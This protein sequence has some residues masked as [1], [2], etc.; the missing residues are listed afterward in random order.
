MVMTKGM[1]EDIVIKA[2]FDGS[3][4]ERG[5]DRLRASAKSFNADLT[6]RLTGAFAATA[7]LDRGIGMAARTFEKFSDIAD[8]AER[9]GISAED[10]QRLGYAAELSGTSMEAAAKAMREIRNATAEAA[11]GNAR[12]I[13]SLMRLGFTEAEVRSGN[14]KSIDVLMKMAQAY[15]RA[16]SDA[17]KFSVAT[18]ILSA[19]TGSEMMPMLAESDASLQQAMSRDV[20]SQE[21]VDQFKT[22]GDQAKEASQAL[23]LM[24]AQAMGWVM[25]GWSSTVLVLEGVLDQLGSAAARARDRNLPEN[26]RKKAEQEALGIFG[27][28]ERHTRVALLG[29]TIDGEFMTKEKVDGI[30]D[31][32]FAELFSPELQRRRAEAKKPSAKQTAEAVGEAMSMPVVASSLAQ[33]GGGGGVYGGPAQM[34]DLA[35]RTASATERTANAV[36]RLANREFGEP[37]PVVNDN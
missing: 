14:L 7:L 2:G 20:V 12:A 28:Y 18:S 22:L 21:M 5:L 10:F 4:A 16:G 19:R 17:E 34:V 31:Q 32:K 9:A 24:T 1:A 29:R 23:E 26:E 30:L 11:E 33:I 3:K 13:E 27:E 8:R 37:E 15:K 6:A 35:D 25:R 36:E